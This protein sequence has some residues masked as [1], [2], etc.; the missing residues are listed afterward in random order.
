MVEVSQCDRCLATYS[1]LSNEFV[2]IELHEAKRVTAWQLCKDCAEIILE[3][4]KTPE[5]K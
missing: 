3:A 1:V 5:N 2:R 4:M